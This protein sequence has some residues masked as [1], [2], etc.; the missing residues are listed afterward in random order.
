M[1][2]TTLFIKLNELKLQPLQQRIELK[3][4]YC[5]HMDTIEQLKIDILQRLKSVGVCQFLFNLCLYSFYFHDF[6]KKNNLE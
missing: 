6:S 3:K 1:N 2:A 4:Y 5:N